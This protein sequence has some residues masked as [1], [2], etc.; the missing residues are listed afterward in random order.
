MSSKVAIRQEIWEEMQQQGV[1]RFPGAQGRIPNFVGAEAAADR[2]DELD[3]WA[4]AKTLKA[5]PDSPQ[6]PARRLA[7]RAGKRVYMAVPRLRKMACFIELDPARIPPDE[8]DRAATIKGADQHG[9]PV[10]LEEM[11]EIDLILTGAVAVD[12]AGHRVGKGG[13]YSDLE[14]GLAREAGLVDGETPIITTVHEVQ[15][16]EEE[17]PHQNHDITLDWII[18]PE[19][20]IA[21]AR[22]DP[23]P[24]GILWDLLPEEKIEAIPVLAARRDK[25]L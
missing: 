16:V 21:C 15:I 20:V 7:L 10:R 17:L 24:A 4:K 23:G 3:V 25:N 5:N 18:S 19:Q 9:R 8:L 2:L 1:D 14:F 6:I 22:R 13:G 12:R 11:P